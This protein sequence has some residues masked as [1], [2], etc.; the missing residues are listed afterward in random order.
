MVAYRL[1]TLQNSDHILLLDDMRLVAI[2]THCELTKNNDYYRSFVNNQQV[3][4]LLNFYQT[5]MAVHSSERFTED[6]E[7]SYVHACL[8]AYLFHDP[9]P[10]TPASNLN[11]DKFYQLLI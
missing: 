3:F 2:G 10:I 4:S 5:M 1:A 7:E 6:L 9:N 11:W 8:D